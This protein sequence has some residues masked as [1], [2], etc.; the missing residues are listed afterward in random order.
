MSKVNKNILINKIIVFLLKGV[1]FLLPLFF[2]PWT[3]D[4]FDFN[5]QILLWLVV[6]FIFLLWL[7]NFLLSNRFRYLRTPFEFPILIFL[8]LS[9]VSVLFSLS[10]QTSLF[11]SFFHFDSAWLGLFSYCLLYFLVINIFSLEDIKGTQKLII[12]SFGIT[13]IITFL[14]ASGISGEIYNNR[15][16]NLVGGLN[17]ELA[18]LTG[19]FSVLLLFNLVFQDWNDK[20]IWQNL[21]LFILLLFSW[22]LLI[23]FNSNPAWWSMLIAGLM[24]FSIYLLKTTNTKEKYRPFSFYKIFWLILPIILP[25]VFLLNPNTTSEL[26]S[27]LDKAPVLDHNT[28]WQITY[29]SLKSNALLGSG[30]GTF[31]N[32]FS[33]YRSKEFN[34]SSAWQYRFNRAS[35]YIS[36]LIS[37]SGALAAVSYLFLLGLIYYLVLIFFS[38][39]W[40]R[41]KERGFY[42]GIVGALLTLITGQFLYPAS[43]TL[44][45]LFWVL[46]ALLVV[47]WR[48]LY[49]DKSRGINT[50]FFKEIKINL[51]ENLKLKTIIY[52]FS[53]LFFS[54]WILISV[55]SIKIWIA[56]YYFKYSNHQEKKLI[57]ATRLNPSQMQYKTSLAKF[58][59]NKVKSL[60]SVPLANQNRQAVQEAIDL[61]VITAR[62][63]VD[64]APYSTIAQETLGMIYR[65]ISPLAQGSEPWAAKAFQEAIKSEPTNPVLYTELGK[66]YLAM[67][68]NDNAITTLLKAK[69]LKEDYYEAQFNLARAYART[70]DF[71]KAINFLKDLIQEY[72][73]PDVY[74]ELGRL[75]YNQGDIDGAIIQFRQAITTSPNHS[76]SL[77]SLGLAY[78]AKGETEE[79]LKYFLKALD[80][81][82][83]NNEIIQKIEAIRNLE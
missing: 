29:E 67:G 9:L 65:D 76:N 13:V 63:A 49:L 70:N 71:N 21:I 36:E 69:E 43:T 30:P 25:C 19:A 56:D 34:N 33:L 26:P 24:V 50:S 15:L 74:F 80:L 83:G 28:S 7:I 42:L 51:K 40:G 75:L 73:S 77:Y 3:L 17:G 11:G 53:F 8:S 79:A 20:K 5:K 10:N 62:G 64:I 78:E 35:S 12:L 31:N 1:V 81:N 44:Q 82:P 38:L 32:L 52:I 61:A 14:T 18:I 45:F 37:T 58:Y 2:L 47:Y 59:L 54:F 60:T 48:E 23:A 66:I 39:A 4:L 22:L 68:E 41:R 57:R 6:P 55:W 27:G 46:L 72:K 16:I